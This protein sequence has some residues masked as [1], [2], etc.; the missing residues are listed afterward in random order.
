MNNDAHDD[1]ELR[2]D[3]PRRDR[4]RPGPD[5][6]EDSLAETWDAPD[7]AVD[8]RL[9]A[10]VGPVTPLYPPPYGYERVALRARR[11]RHRTAFIAAAAGVMAVAVAAG[12]VIAGTHLNGR[13]GLQVAGCNAAVGRAAPA[14]WSGDGWLAGARRPVEAGGIDSG[15]EVT[16]RKY[17]WAIGGLLTAA[18]VSVGIVAGCSSNASANGPSAGPTDSGGP[19]ASQTPGTVTLP[20]PSTTPSNG[21]PSSSSSAAGG[22]PRCHTVDLSPAVSIVAGSQ[23]AGH[24][25]INIRLTN[26]SGHTCTV[27]GFPGMMLE[28]HN[29]SGQATNVTRNHGIPTTTITVADGASVATT[30]RI[31]FDVPA[32]D[33]PQTGN[34]EIPSVYLQITPPDETTQL[35]ATITGGP[36]TVCEHGTIDVLPF[37]SGPT[38][39]NQ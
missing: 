7:A 10:L 6:F 26:T 29:G 2:P 11:R 15:K 17:E 28:D 21:S 30:G 34:C 20:A 22:P 23:G 4:R 8:R 38:G 35:V 25:S 18:A 13:S 14:A 31:D 39:A 9:R 1:G 19:S 24:E 32:A 36:V 16:V 33:E 3:D 27:R 37:V 5:P 12:G